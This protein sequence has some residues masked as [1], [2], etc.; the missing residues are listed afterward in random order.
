MKCL[1][2]PIWNQV[3]IEA[4]DE[5]ARAAVNAHWDQ[6]AKPI[7]GLGTFETIIAKIGAIQKTD[8]VSIQKRAVLI[9]C[10]DNGIVAE[11]ISQSGQEVTAAVAK[12]MAVHQSSV[13][14]M[15]EQIGMDTFPIDIGI[16]RK[17]PIDGVYD[18]KVR[19]GTENFLKKP[20][21]TAAE[22]ERAIHTGIE[23][24]RACKE[25]GYELLAAG[26]M[27][28]GNTTTSSALASALLGCPA[29]DVT[30]RGAGLKDEQL[31]R[32]ISVIEAGLKKHGL[33]GKAAESREQVFSA[34]CLVGGLD[35]AGLCGVCIGSAVYRIPIV[36]DGVIS[37][38]SALLAERMFPGTKEFLIASHKGKEPAME[39]LLNELGL[40]AVIDA[41]MALGEGT[42]AVMMT[43]LLDMALAVYN[44]HNTF[45]E[46]KIEQYERY[47]KR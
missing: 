31:E 24:V 8:R 20:A 42:G 27:G 38:V 25:K 41:D 10:A 1:E 34:L 47:Q 3:T 45:N 15:A 22:A 11:G 14:R 29:K 39:R 5:T 46:W 37:A 21:M 16:N 36:L 35:L 7:D 18:R 43:G 13:G 4:P 32:K 28:I 19:C 12:K 9:L 33:Y 44:S 6:I 2:M 30:G 23:L 26:E 17:E 40:S